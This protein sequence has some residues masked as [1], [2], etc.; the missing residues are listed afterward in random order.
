MAT[1]KGMGKMRACG[2]AGVTTGKMQ[3]K[4]QGKTL[5]LS[6][7]HVIAEPVAGG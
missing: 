7:C 1:Y 2:G 4:V 3:G 5:S 6:T